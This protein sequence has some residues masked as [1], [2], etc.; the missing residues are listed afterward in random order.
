M[1]ALTRLVAFFSFGLVGLF[2]FRLLLVCF[3]FRFV[4]IKVEN[5]FAANKYLYVCI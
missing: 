4:E 5:N 3:Y 1:Q 2:R